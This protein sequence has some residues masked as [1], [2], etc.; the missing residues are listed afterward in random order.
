MKI[1]FINI[2]CFTS[3]FFRFAWAQKEANYWVFGEGGGLNFTNNQLNFFESEVDL[4]GVTAVVSDQNSGE[5]LF[6]SDGLY[7]WNKNHE[8][9]QNGSEIKT[10]SNHQDSP[11]IVPSQPLIIVPRPGINDEYYLFHL[12]EIE[13]SL[14]ENA[15]LY[16]T[17]VNT[18][19]NN[20]NGEVKQGD[21]NFFVKGNLALKI[22][23]VPHANGKDFWLITHAADNNDFYVYLISDE[24]LAGPKVI[25]SGISYAVNNSENY[26]RGFIKASPN[27]NYIAVSSLG[28]NRRFE[29]FSFNPGTGDISNPVS[30]G[31]F[32][33]QYGLSFSPDNTKLYLRGINERDYFHQ[34][35][36]LASNIA[37]SRIGLFRENPNLGDHVVILHGSVELAPDGK[38]Y[39]RGV[40][41]ND[42]QINGLGIISN[43]NA[44]GWEVNFEIVPE[45]FEE[46][47][48]ISGGLPNLIQSTFNGITPNRNPNSPCN[49]ASTFQLSPNPAKDFI[50]IGVLEKCFTSYRLTI[51]RITGQ[52]IVQY[53]IKNQDSGELPIYDLSSGIYLAVLEF[54]NKRIVK[55]FYKY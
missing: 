50:K 8:I 49:E 34:F 17:I 2:L 46:D 30:L 55:K 54:E 45:P 24:G 1:I 11:R 5:L 26:I 48:H 44:L 18:G 47:D 19:L 22:T 29:L 32:D 10:G 35:N 9:M 33:F 25:S 12:N 51:Y 39:V 20:G 6:Y 23:A 15:D 28:E 37:N 53:S 4:F 41:N 7:I 27:G 42:E 36:L 52:K 14:L 31:N 43:P 40:R 38:L 3:L 16:Y 13:S 21:K